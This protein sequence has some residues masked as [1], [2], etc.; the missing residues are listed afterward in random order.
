MMLRRRLAAFLLCLAVAMAGWG[1]SWWP[2]TSETSKACC[3]RICPCQE[4]KCALQAG[5]ERSDNP[6]LAV[7]LP[8][9]VLPTFDFVF[10]SVRPRLVY[11]PF[12]E[13]GWRWAEEG[14]GPPGRAP[15]WG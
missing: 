3:G 10:P 12:G 8:V 9:A 2:R 7:I 15:P 14:R 13:E 5:P 4:C 6:T 1:V 11:M